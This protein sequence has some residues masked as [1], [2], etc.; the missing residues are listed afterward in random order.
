MRHSR[1][2]F[3]AA[4]A[5]IALFAG[6]CSSNSTTPTTPTPPAA[7]CAFAL[8]STSAS[9]NGGGDTLTVNIGAT[10]ATCTW[11]AASN[12]AFITVKSGATGTGNGSVT[13][14][15]AA[16]PGAARTGTATIAGQT[17]TV[18]QSSGL[19]AAFSLF[20]PGQTSTATNECRFR[21]GASNPNTC[22]LRSTSFT[23][24]ATAIVTY[25]WAV[26]YTFGTV[27]TISQTGAT[28][29]LDITDKCGQDGSTDDGAANPLSVTLTVTDS[30]GNSTTATSGVGSQPALQ[31][32]MF[33]CGL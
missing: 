31:I 29:S 16:N 9:A 17:F 12:S 19:V 25:T 30:K 26:Q 21:S 3:S 8:G 23:F 2:L 18:N 33:T 4:V 14:T 27:K 11:A 22:T 28:P 20:D 15:I 5:T 6:A 24:D 32:K 1:L 7:S 10:A 13:L